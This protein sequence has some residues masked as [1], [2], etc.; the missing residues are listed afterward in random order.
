MSLRHILLCLSIV[1]LAFHAQGLRTDDLKCE[2][3]YDPLGIDNTAPHFSW[4]NYSPR[5]NA[6]QT[7]W[8]IQVGT[9]SVKVSRGEADLWNSGKRLS[10]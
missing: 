6:R 9:D 7:A 2:N 4:K 3:L 8:E 5:N 10:A 1:P